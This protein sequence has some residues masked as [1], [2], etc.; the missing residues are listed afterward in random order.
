MDRSFAGRVVVITG[1]SSGIGRATAHAFAGRG[2]T[3]LLATLALVGVPLG[4]M[5][6]RQWRSVPGHRA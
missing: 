4:L 6:S 3:V 2:A 5:A 1:A